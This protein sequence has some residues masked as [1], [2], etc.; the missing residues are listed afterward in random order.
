[1]TSP[2]PGWYPDPSGAPALKWWDGYHW[3]DHQQYQSATAQPPGPLGGWYAP[4]S[5]SAPTAVAVQRHS[6][7]VKNTY[8]SITFGV[9]ALYLVLTV[10]AGISVLG[11]LPAL[12]TYRSFRAQEKL[13]PVA[14]IATVVAI[15]FALW[16][17]SH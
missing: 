2:A 11:I 10:S 13:A 3:T 5:T 17:R 6:A 14:L 9:V 12:M 16:V 1:M 4:G 15:G 8:A 7:R